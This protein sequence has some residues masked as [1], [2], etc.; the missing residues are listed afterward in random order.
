MVV[1][2][3]LDN[4]VRLLD[5]SGSGLNGSF[6]SVMESTMAYHGGHE[7]TSLSLLR[8]AVTSS[9]KFTVAGTE[10]GG[11]QGPAVYGT[12]D[13]KCLAKL[14]TG[15]TPCYVEASTADRDEIAIGGYGV[16]GAVWRTKQD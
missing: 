2:Y 16:K 14:A 10:S 12:K 4:V 1:A 8:A 5:V 3:Y 11:G 9:G 13:G 7:G 15:G 6:G